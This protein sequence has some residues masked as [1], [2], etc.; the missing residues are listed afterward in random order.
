MSCY[1]RPEIGVLTVSS[2]CFS[3]GWCS[4]T[5]FQTEL[6]PDGNAFGGGFAD[7]IRYL[8]I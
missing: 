8:V 1:L 6:R 5:I 3:P 2:D 7:G 4:V